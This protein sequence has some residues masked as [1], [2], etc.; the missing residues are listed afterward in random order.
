MRRIEADEAGIILQSEELCPVRVV[1][2]TSPV[3]IK[4]SNQNLKYK[5]NNLPSP[6]EPDAL[7]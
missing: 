6:H 5:V 1:R 3:E 7:Y 2:I 4:K